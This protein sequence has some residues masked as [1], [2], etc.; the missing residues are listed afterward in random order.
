MAVNMVI[1]NTWLNINA[2]SSGNNRSYPVRKKEVI[3]D[4]KLN[5]R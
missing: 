1:L 2:I 3:I 4:K 5:A